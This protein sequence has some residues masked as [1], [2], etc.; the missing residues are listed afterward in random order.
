MYG[1]D[2]A[3]F[4]GGEPLHLRPKTILYVGRLAPIKNVV[5]L[6]Q[7]FA[8]FA[9]D[10][11]DWVLRICGSGGQ[12]ALLPDHAQIQVED[13]VQPPQL[14]EIMREARCL[15]L[16]S[17][18]EPWGVVVHEA[19]LSGCALAL[20]T[21]VGAADDLARPDNAV[22]FKPRSVAAIEGALRTIAGWDD[23]QW[24][25]AEQTSRELA[26]QFGPERFADAVDRF[27]EILGV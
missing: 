25:R 23:Q 11:P 9:K 24:Q 5:G 17:L 18:H 2:P 3:L 4:H 12:R 27:I 20:S 19:A 10:H 15:V 1:A 7:A 21:A 26:K 6:T 13:F 14:A 16:P 8:A 22:L